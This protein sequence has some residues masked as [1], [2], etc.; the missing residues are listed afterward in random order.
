MEYKRAVSS[1]C[2]WCDDNLESLK[3]NNMRP[4]N[5]KCESCLFGISLSQEKL[6]ELGEF[7][8]NGIQ[9]RS[10]YFYDRC[11]AL[12]IDKARDLNGKG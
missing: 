10:E 3:E 6:A 2:K 9:S 7:V 11:T 1:E 5:E 8:L 12:I 4:V